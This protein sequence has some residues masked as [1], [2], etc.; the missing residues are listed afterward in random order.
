[1]IK[2]HVTKPKLLFN[3]KIPRI[4]HYCWFG[5]KPLPS[6]V[7]K[8]LESWKKYLPDFI[9][10][11]WDEDSF[12]IN[13]HS[14]TKEAYE[15]KSWAFITDYVRL[16]VLHQFGGVY[17][18]SDVEIIKP[19]DKFLI[20]SAFTSFESP[21]HVPTGLMASINNHLWIKTL[22]NYYNNKHFILRDGK[23][24]I[25]PNTHIIT[26]ISTEIFDL[27]INNSYQILSSD[28]HIYPSEYFSPK[29]YVTGE[30]NLTE[31]TY[32]IHH[33]SGSWKPKHQKYEK[34]FW[35]LIGLKNLMVIDRFK[36]LFRKIIHLI[37][38]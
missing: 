31:N 15:N 35:T 10:L 11:R 16:Y 18:D 2:V 36:N 6:L 7:E 27:Q 19:I 25:K 12:D 4:I 26:E 8:C 1:M 13:A 14:F 28:V 9:I 33:F 37:S 23:L 24:D 32:C 21:F 29:S 3:E 34:Y 17:L 30:I 5:G 38:R 20:H 22:L